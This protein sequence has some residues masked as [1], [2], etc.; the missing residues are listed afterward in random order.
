[1]W[2]VPMISRIGNFTYST[3]TACTAFV[4]RQLKVHDGPIAFGGGP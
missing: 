4:D 1:M 3:R 2:L